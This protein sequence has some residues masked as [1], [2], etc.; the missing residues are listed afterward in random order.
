MVVTTFKTPPFTIDRTK[1]G[2]L[3]VQLA[4]A[5][6]RAIQTGYYRPGEILPPIRELA[7]LT[8]LSQVITTR[9]IRILKEER[10]ISPRPRVGCVVCATDGPLWNGQI[11]V[12]VPP[13]YGKLAQNAAQAALRDTLTS[14]GYLVIPATVPFAADGSMDFSIL[15]TMARHRFDIIVNG[16]DRE[17]VFDHLASLGQPF[18]RVTR[19]APVPCQDLVG[20]V[21]RRDDLCL[22]EFIAHCRM[23]GVRKVV[24]VSSAVD[25]NGPDT[26][27]ALAAAGVQ[28]EDWRI[29]KPG[30]RSDTHSL[31]S[32]SAL[33]FS[34]RL[35]GNWAPRADGRRPLP[36]LIFFRDD[37]LAS[38][39]MLALAA[40][41]VRIPQD[42]HIV[43]WADKEDLPACKVPL[44]RMER[45]NTAIGIQVAGYVLD[46]LHSGVF[47]ENRTFGPRYIR[48]E[49]F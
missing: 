24:Q 6:R 29:A 41:G 34:K 49:T 16:Y 30:H 46:Y 47:P 21:V 31:S 5:L 8:G 10:L 14:A 25:N 20:T 23:R 7:A 11:L 48:G 26:L 35:S 40:A 44:T 17:E 2:L 22:P 36:D 27:P 42:V 13:G 18:V 9:A 43:T 32:E 12:V 33:A 37:R 3:S 15:D 45:D 38:G 1:R 28:A 39:A 4:D 19:Q